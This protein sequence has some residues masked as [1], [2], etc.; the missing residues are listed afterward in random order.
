MDTQSSST[1][2]GLYA[3]VLVLLIISI[4][5]WR[6][7]ISIKKRLAHNV[8]LTKNRA[9]HMAQDQWFVEDV[10]FVPFTERYIDGWMKVVLSQ[11]VDGSPPRLITL[12]FRPEHPSYSLAMSLKKGDVVW[13]RFEEQAL[14]PS[15]NEGEAN[16]LTITIRLSPEAA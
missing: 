15:S 9:R 5:V 10:A 8:S 12:Y 14:T 3:L 16:H 6:M 4:F 2:S 1:N 11:P 7:G 13:F